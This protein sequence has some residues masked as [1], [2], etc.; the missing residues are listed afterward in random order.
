M[1][2]YKRELN[3]DDLENLDDEE[4]LIYYK[5]DKVAITIDIVK[6]LF[7]VRK[8]SIFDNKLIEEAFLKTIGE[9]MEFV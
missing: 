8:K 4:E 6:D 9:V 1:I 7:I 3:A 5:S 2:V